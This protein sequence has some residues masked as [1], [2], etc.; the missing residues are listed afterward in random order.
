ME[1]VFL[2]TNI[3]IRSLTQD[4]LEMAEQARA[5]L[6]QAERGTLTL[7]A[8][9]AILVEAVNV[10]SSPRLYNLPRHQV[11]QG[12]VTI[13]A[14]PNIK[15]PAK[16]TLRRAL[17]LWAGSSVDFVD[18]LS[19]AHMERWRLRSIASFDNDFNRFRQ[20]KRLEL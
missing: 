6:K 15:F 1:S 17:S 13:L 8:S 4:N 10:L 3:V 18:A 9:E 19:V 14:V 5:L 16:R 7:V 12:L 20:I 2:D 11:A